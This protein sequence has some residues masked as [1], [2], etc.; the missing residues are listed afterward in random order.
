[1]FRDYHKTYLPHRAKTIY[2][3]DLYS[4]IIK[5]Q[6]LDFTI[7]PNEDPFAHST[8]KKKKGFSLEEYRKVQDRLAQIRDLIWYLKKNLSGP[9]S[10]RP[11]LIN[12]LK[13]TVETVEKT[14]SMLDR[15]LRNFHGDDHGLFTPPKTERPFFDQ[16]IT[17]ITPSA[18]FLLLYIKALK[19]DNH[20]M[21]FKL[22]AMVNGTQGE[23]AA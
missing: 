4:K 21:V 16:S 19:E 20:Q 18:A 6:K 7:I 14:I 5:I 8:N 17:D 12:Q 1:M 13:R 22:D 11:K 3:K 2:Y 10:H 15:R 9:Y 23:E